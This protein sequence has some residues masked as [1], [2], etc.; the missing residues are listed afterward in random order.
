VTHEVAKV[1]VVAG[2]EAIAAD[3]GLDFLVPP[4]VE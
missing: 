4:L 1:T 3:S 2:G